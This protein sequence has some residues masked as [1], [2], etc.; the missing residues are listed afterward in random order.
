MLNN[1]WNFIDTPREGTMRQPADW[2]RPMDDRILEIL[3][4]AG[5]TLSCHHRI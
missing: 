2:M 3:Q 4:T 1:R 5:I